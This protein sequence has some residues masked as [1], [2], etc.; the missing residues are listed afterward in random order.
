MHVSSG[1][2]ERGDGCERPQR[3][4]RQLVRL[5]ALLKCIDHAI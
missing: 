1:G 2:C 5:N 4:G 3:Q